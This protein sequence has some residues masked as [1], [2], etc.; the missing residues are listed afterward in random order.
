MRAGNTASE[1]KEVVT[2]TKPTIELKRNKGEIIIRVSD[3]EEVTKVIYEIN[4]TIYTKENN[5]DNKKEYEIRDLL[6]KGENIIKVTAYNKAGLT[7]EK[8]GKCTY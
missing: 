2:V 7:A 4:G 8:V 1:E 5:G 6:T 3:N